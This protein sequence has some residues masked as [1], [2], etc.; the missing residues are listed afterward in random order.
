MDESYS[1]SVQLQQDRNYVMFRLHA[2][3]I[4]SQP[5]LS[6][7]AAPQFYQSHESVTSMYTST[8]ISSYGVTSLQLHVLVLQ[9]CIRL[10]CAAIFSASS[11][12]DRS[13]CA[14]LLANK[15]NYCNA[16]LADVSAHLYDGLQSVLNAAT[17][18]IFSARKSKQPL[19]RTSLTTCSGQDWISAVR[20]RALLP[21]RHDA[22]IPCRQSMPCC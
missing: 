16:V 19:P 20:S 12:A 22:F 2:I 17:W 15:L 13:S 6:V 8:A 14:G 5:E 10:K 1:A 4:I 9:H 3:G 7:S 21:S 18:V 11:P